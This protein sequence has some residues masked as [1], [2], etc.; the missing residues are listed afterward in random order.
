MKG[1]DGGSYEKTFSLATENKHDPQDFQS[2]S[3]NKF[4]SISY[5]KSYNP[6][7]IFGMTTAAFIQ[8]DSH[9]TISPSPKGNRLTN[10]L[11]E[12][13]KRT[14][15]RTFTFFNYIENRSW[16]LEVQKEPSCTP[17]QLSFPLDYFLYG[18]NQRHDP[19]RNGPYGTGNAP[20]T[21]STIRVSW[22]NRR[23]PNKFWWSS[24]NWSTSHCKRQEN[25]RYIKSNYT[26]P[27]D[28]FKLTQSCFFIIRFSAVSSQN[29][30]F[31]SDWPKG[32]IY[33]PFQLDGKGS[34]SIFSKRRFEC[35]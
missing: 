14:Q 16:Y 28:E 6:I 23:W 21:S 19:L 15:L 18:S 8:R 17:T 33:F 22:Y 20:D 25:V 27:N 1:N 30:L 35:L 5:I 7:S 10:N 31:F 26:G 3:R 13:H 12:K 24:E 32:L 2:P 9:E 29:L 34:Y 4:M 11:Y